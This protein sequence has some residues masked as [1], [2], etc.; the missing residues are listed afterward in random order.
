MMVLGTIR[1]ICTLADY[2]NAYIEVARLDP[3]SFR[4]LGSFLQENHPLIAIGAAWPLILGLALRRTRWPELLKATAATFLILSVGGL[5][6]VTTDWN[7]SRDRWITLGSFRVPHQAFWHPGFSDLLLGLLGAIQ[8]LLELGIA[9]R[10]VQLAYQVH[11]APRDNTEKHAAAR[12]ARFGRLAIYGSIAYLVLMIRL[13]VWSAYLELLNQSRFVREFILQNDFQRIRSSRP[14][15]LSPLEAE[16]IRD[17]GAMLANA[18]QAWGS[19]RFGEAKDQYLRLAAL[20]ESIPPSTLKAPTYRGAAEGLNNLAWLLATCPIDALRE[21]HDAVD[22]ARR[23]IELVPTEGNFWNTLG[24]AYYRAELWEKARSALFQSI[25]LRHDGDSFDWF[26]LA[27]IHAR[28]GHKERAHEWYT[29]ASQW[30]Q[31]N[32]PGDEE[33]YRFQVE[34]AACL[35]LGKPEPPATPQQLGPPVMY[36]TPM[37]LPRR[38]RPRIIDPSLPAP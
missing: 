21:P 17:L 29:R 33:L 9:V 7:Q 19:G 37:L 5:L 26:F 34:A 12:R 30:F 6:A 2:V 35:G 28:L 15:V 24:V 20:V 27:M 8:L 32:R 10:A 1:L 3:L 36:R 13:P 11:A 14:L 31:Q 16:R 23:A 38:G 18:T 4:R 22:Y 25:E